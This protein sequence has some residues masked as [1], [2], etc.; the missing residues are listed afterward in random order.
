MCI[1]DRY[2]PQEKGPWSQRDSSQRW[3]RDLLFLDKPTN[4]F[5]VRGEVQEYNLPADGRVW[6]LNTGFKHAVVNNGTEPRIALLLTLKT[7]EDIECL[8]LM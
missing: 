7:Q 2:R 5:W 3:Y 8:K 1:R 6:F 4:Y